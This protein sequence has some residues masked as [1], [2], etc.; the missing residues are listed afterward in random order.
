MPVCF[1]HMANS[2]DVFVVHSGG[3]LTITKFATEIDMTALEFCKQDINGYLPCITINQSERV[4][5]HR[6]TL[7]LSDSPQ[8]RHPSPVRGGRGSI[9]RVHR[10]SAGP[11]AHLRSTTGRA[12][13]EV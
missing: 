11:P 5:L 9:K 13:L 6:K 3:W 7:A 10:G 2:I 4:N 8:P 12:A 1:Y